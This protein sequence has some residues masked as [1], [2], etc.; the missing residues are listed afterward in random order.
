[1]DHE[2]R[3]KGLWRECVTAFAVRIGT[4]ALHAPAR[5]SAGKQE[6]ESSQI[7][8]ISTPVERQHA[9]DVDLLDIY[10]ILWSFSKD[11]LNISNTVPMLLGKIRLVGARM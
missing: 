1:V 8:L 3:G 2:L 5:G 4:L 6:G 10:R 9:I 7:P 11:R